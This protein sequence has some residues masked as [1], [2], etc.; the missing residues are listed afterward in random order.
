M[1][2]CVI[3]LFLHRLLCCPPPRHQVTMDSHEVS[4]EVT[5]VAI[6]G[7]ESL[8]EEEIATQEHTNTDEE[9]SGMVFFYRTIKAIF[10]TF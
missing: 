5:D 10:A 6:D 3:W 2:H 7:G 4:G 9:L 1:L 8:A